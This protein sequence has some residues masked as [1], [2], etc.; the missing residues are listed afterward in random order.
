MKKGMFLILIFLSLTS[1]Q[2][3]RQEEKKVEKK[4]EKQKNFDAK[5][6][7]KDFKKKIVN[8]EESKVPEYKLPELLKCLDGQ[9]VKTI[10][11]W[12]NKRRPEIKKLFEEHMYGKAPGKP[13]G[14][15]FTLKSI[16]KKALG[17]KAIK[18]EIRVNFFGKADGPGMNMLVYL[19]PQAKKPV[20]LF[21]V[22]NFS[23]NA[24]I[25]G[26][27]KNKWPLE[28]ILSQGY[29]VATAC[30]HDIDPDKNNFSDGIH[31]SYYK[32]GQTKPLPNE[33]G[34]IAA[35]AWGLSR[36][37]DYFET[38]K[39]V[40]HKKVIVMGH[41]RLGKTSLWAGATDERFALV[42]S[43]NS[44]CGGAALSRRA[45]GET[46]GKINYTFPH[47]FCDN[48]KKYNHNEG[49]LPLDQHMLVALMAPRPVYV[50]SAHGD[51]WADPKGE[52]LSAKHA[53][54]IYQLYGYTKNPLTEPP[55]TNQTVMGRIGY[56]K[57]SG[58]HDV[59]AFDWQAYI[60]FA[61]LHLK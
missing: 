55:K 8:Y 44:G 32:K 61:K 49:A 30:Y 27:R 29:G 1:C 37:L 35:W 23:G 54:P 50:A 41:S 51:R 59:T 2:E 34:S 15:S 26:S 42:I 18:K 38:D 52:F 40:D 16:D 45:V 56:H 39:D 53:Q 46:V 7:Y 13:K 10:K 24:S 57:R 43:N 22:L 11:D 60:K 47:W 48:F 20:S 9:K 5:K 19:P 12:K 25:F 33:W 58:K 14:L 3:E 28:Y 17:G 31:P 6:H 21:W 4:A 36:G